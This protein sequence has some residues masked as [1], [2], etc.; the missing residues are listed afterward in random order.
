MSLRMFRL[1]Q[2]FG[3]TAIKKDATVTQQGP[4]K[5]T[6]LESFQDFSILSLIYLKRI[7]EFDL[8]WLLTSVSGGCKNVVT[9]SF[10]PGPSF[11]HTQIIIVKSIRHA[12]FL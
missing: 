5:F 10:H 6:L 12:L 2:N 4:T 8:L 1:G 7:G 11:H 9:A 3:L